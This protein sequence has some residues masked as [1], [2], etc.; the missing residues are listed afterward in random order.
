MRFAAGLAALC[1]AA[2]AAGQ[3]AAQNLSTEGSASF[4]ASGLTTTVTTVKTS[5][6]MLSWFACSNSNASAEFVQVFD[7]TSS[8]TLGTTTPKLALPIGPS[9]VTAL[10]IPIGSNFLNGI[11]IAA[12]T[13]PTGST[14]PGTAL[15][16]SIGYF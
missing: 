16:C 11:K 5:A 3:A 14:A 9:G 15:N 8:V 6:G 7:T 10:A 2:L 4:V 1:L 13:T 12:T